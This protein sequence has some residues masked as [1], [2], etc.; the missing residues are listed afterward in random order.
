LNF[1]KTPQPLSAE[2]HSHL[3][4]L[5]TSKPGYITIHKRDHYNRI[6]ATVH[7]SR[8]NFTPN[9]LL[10]LLKRGW[11]LLRYGSGY[12]HVGLNMV[13]VGLACVY[14]GSDEVFGGYKERLVK[15]EE[16]AR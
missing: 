12:E 7:V 3:S 16:K 5:V 1:R 6:V 9:P 15:E 2:A 8:L 14:E 10:L 13:A 4:T 11:V